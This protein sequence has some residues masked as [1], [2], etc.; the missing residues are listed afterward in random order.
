MKT[1]KEILINAEKSKQAIFD[2]IG[3]NVLNIWEIQKAT[4]VGES[5]IKNHLNTLINREHIT[6][7]KIKRSDGKWIANYRQTDKLFVCK[8]EEEIGISDQE[9]REYTKRYASD[10]EAMK[11]NPNLQIYRRLD[12]RVETAKRSSKS[13]YKGIGSSFSMWESA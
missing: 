10:L 3:N 13:S 5:V 12:T 9:K 11:A 6:Q 8:T 2:C 7:S 4:G 1:R